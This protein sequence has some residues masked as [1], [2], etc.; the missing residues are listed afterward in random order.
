MLVPI[1]H[2]PQSPHLWSSWRD[3]FWVFLWMSP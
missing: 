2:S 3:D 1:R